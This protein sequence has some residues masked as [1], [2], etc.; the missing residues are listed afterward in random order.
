MGKSMYA[1]GVIAT[2]HVR[3]MGGEGSNVCHFGAYVRIE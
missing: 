3:T 2:V 1:M